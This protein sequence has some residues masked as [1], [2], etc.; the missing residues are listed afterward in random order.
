MRLT[1]RSLLALLDDPA[2][3]DQLRNDLRQELA[4]DSH[5]T[6]IAQK[7]DGLLSKPR[8]AAP[9]IDALGTNDANR[10]A[11]YLDVSLPTELLAR[12]EQSCLKSEPLLAEVACCHQIVCHMHQQELEISP[13]LR[14]RIYQ[15][16]FQEEP[17]SELGT[18]NTDSDVVKPESNQSVISERAEGDSDPT[19]GT[20][21]IASTVPKGQDSEKSASEAETDKA[22]TQIGEMQP[23]QNVLPKPEESS[24]KISQEIHNKTP[25]ED[26]IARPVDVPR[27]SAPA[28]EIKDEKKVVLSSSAKVTRTSGKVKQEEETGSNRGRWYVVLAIISLWFAVWFTFPQIRQEVW[29]GGPNKDAS[30]NQEAD[31]ADKTGDSNLAVSLPDPSEP[32]SL[33]KPTGNPVKQLPNLDRQTQKLPIAGSLPTLDSTSDNRMEQTESSLNVASLPTLPSVDSSKKEGLI[34]SLPGSANQ[35]DTP[36]LLSDT[37]KTLVSMAQPKNLTSNQRNSGDVDSA[38]NR[39][40]P[41]SPAENLSANRQSGQAATVPNQGDNM[42]S[43]LPPVEGTPV[44]KKETKQTNLDAGLEN[45]PSTIQKVT[46]EETFEL[47]PVSQDTQPKTDSNVKPTS[48]LSSDPSPAISSGPK[49]PR[50][51]WTQ[52][53][54]TVVENKDGKRSVKVLPLGRSRL[55]VQ[56]QTSGSWTMTF[57]SGAQYEVRNREGWKE[58]LPESSVSLNEGLVLIQ[59]NVKGETLRIHTPIGQISFSNQSDQ[60]QWILEVNPHSPDGVHA[61]IASCRYQVGCLGLEGNVVVHNNQIG[62]EF[63]STNGQIKVQVDG[64]VRTKTIQPPPGILQLAEWCR[65]GKIDATTEEF[66]PILNGPEPTADLAKIVRGKTLDQKT[67]YRKNLAAMWSYS[68]GE[69]DTVFDVL[70]DLSLAGSWEIHIQKVGRVLKTDAEAVNK[71]NQALISRRIPMWVKRAF[72]GFKV[73]TMT[74]QDWADIINGLYDEK[75]QSVRVLAISSLNSLTG[76]NFGYN[77]RLSIGENVEAIKSWRRWWEAGQ[78][79]KLSKR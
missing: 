34:P 50:T 44:A 3:D 77:Q 39:L 53:S 71:F 41:Q 69:L 2:L 28:T 74:E 51:R 46:A 78:F 40:R 18:Q 66:L 7:I 47:P 32:N 20:L 37:E 70:D 79:K 64:S 26:T 25:E 27:Y 61:G 33:S 15:V 23:R 9:K 52:N 5:F 30:E 8:M 19:P 57:S 4:L 67:R 42:F 17:D 21:Q 55:E 1:L 75:N 72:Y 10:V 68:L 63:L 38:R 48:F 54:A 35:S 60:A 24:V 56:S 14:D 16:G 76:E 59:S 12:F 73:E 43:A 62:E 45:N 11:Q 29:S 6:G 22:F 31:S 58:I 13:R 36:K 49:F 65:S